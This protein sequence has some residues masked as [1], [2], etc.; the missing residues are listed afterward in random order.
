MR[1]YPVICFA[2]LLACAELGT[3][4]TPPEADG[5]N[6]AKKPITV[7]KLTLPSDTKSQPALKYQLLPDV[8]ELTPGNAAPLWLRACD[9][10]GPA[11][12]EKE[13]RWLRSETAL[14]DLPRNEVRE[15]LG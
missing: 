9:M 1:T 15:L 2:L 10:V 8:S 5:N 4:Q 6:P 13:D 3:A 7:I 14:R 11:W 12:T